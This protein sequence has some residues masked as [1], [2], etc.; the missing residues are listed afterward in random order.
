MDIRSTDT[1]WHKPLKQ[2]NNF[3]KSF[4]LLRVMTV[5]LKCLIVEMKFGFRRNLLR[6]KQQSKPTENWNKLLPTYHKLHQ[7]CLLRSNTQV[8]KFRRSRKMSSIMYHKFI[9]ERESLEGTNQ[10]LYYIQFHIP[11][12]SVDK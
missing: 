10:S 9:G 11:L 1:S 3:I 7:L 6:I 8:I 2:K 12:K 5:R 4:T